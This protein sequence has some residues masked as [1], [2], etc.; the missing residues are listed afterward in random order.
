MS[1]D[2]LLSMLL[3]NRSLSPMLV[4]DSF[5]ATITMM[6][7]Y[8]LSLCINVITFTNQYKNVY[9]NL[10]KYSPW[11]SMQSILSQLWKYSWYFESPKYT[12]DGLLPNSC[13][14]PAFGRWW[15]LVNSIPAILFIKSHLSLE[16]QNRQCIQMLLAASPRDGG[17]GEAISLAL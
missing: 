12:N 16:C 14:L 17:G 8:V 7:Q 5:K 9:C 3:L 4:N 15:H 13:E 6:D 10:S 1:V 2:F 11:T